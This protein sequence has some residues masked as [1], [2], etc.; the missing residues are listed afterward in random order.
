MSTHPAMNNVTDGNAA[1]ATTPSGQRDSMVWLLRQYASETQGVTHAVLLSRDGLRL[2][3]SDVDKDWADELS[4]AFSGV[5]SLAANITGPS[6]KKRP[7]RQVIIERDDC[8]FFVQSAGCSAAFDNHPG[9]ERGE[10]DT[11]LAV[12]ATRDADV[13]TVGFEMGRLVAKFAPY[14]VI[15]VR[16]GT[17]GEVR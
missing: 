3:D 4:A 2:L 5:A 15:P 9:N 6:H 11:I 7:A 14:M 13:G 12:I 8:L 16:V 10:V 1:S 17:G